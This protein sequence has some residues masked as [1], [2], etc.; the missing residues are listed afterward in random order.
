[1]TQLSNAVVSKNGSVS[2]V[3]SDADQVKKNTENITKISNWIKAQ[4]GKDK[5]DN[6]L[7]KVDLE[8]HRM[9]LSAKTKTRLR[10]VGTS[11]DLSGL[12]QALSKFT[13]ENQKT[14]KTMSNGAFGRAYNYADINAFIDA[15]SQTLQKYGLSFMSRSLG[16]HNN[17]ILLEGVVTWS[18]GENAQW[19]NSLLELE[20]YDYKGEVTN[21]SMGSALTYG[22]RYLMTSLLNLGA[23]DDDGNA[24]NPDKKVAEPKTKTKQNTK[25]GK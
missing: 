6:V 10:S 20:P 2:S 23:D 19:I 12:F 25:K 17:K 9:E 13:G 3:S 11:E 22:R 18:D 24:T 21:Q 7:A 5:S 4:S 14:Q 16:S 15:T 8:K 1:M